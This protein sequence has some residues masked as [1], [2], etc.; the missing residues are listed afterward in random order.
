MP[1]DPTYGPEEAHSA[2]CL[3]VRPAFGNDPEFCPPCSKA[4]CVDDEP[5]QPCRVYGTPQ[6]KW[7]YDDE[8]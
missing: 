5:N 6:E 1:T 7:D 2:S 8:Y 3:C 4:R